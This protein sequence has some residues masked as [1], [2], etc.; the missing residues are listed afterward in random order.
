MF[1][2]MSQ[3]V[4]CNVLDVGGD[5]A[6]EVNDFLQI[7]SRYKK[8]YLIVSP[9]RCSSTA[10]ARVFWEQPSIGYYSHEPFEAAYKKNIDLSHVVNQLEVPLNLTPLKKQTNGERGLGLLVK[11]M[12]FQVGKNFPIL[13]GLTQEPIM[14]L[15]RDPRL[16]IASRMAKKKEGGN[17]PL[18]PLIESG[19]EFIWDQIEY[20]QQQN[21]PYSIVDATNFRNNPQAIFKQVFA[22]LK[23]PFEIEMLSWRSCQ[24]V[25]IDNLEGTQNH[26]YYRVLNS[27]NIQPAT[28]TIPSID[29]FPITAGFRDHVIK[30]LEI[31]QFLGNLPERITSDC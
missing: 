29:S 17:N 5:R 18:F 21:I 28:E 8:K 24:N 13:A 22:K 7:S 4:K 27:T 3:T 26:W 10:F 12:S 1:R 6:Q 11:E 15:I 23:L 30:C 25:K 31:Y 19:W 14:F 20:C 9:P 16:S 2:K